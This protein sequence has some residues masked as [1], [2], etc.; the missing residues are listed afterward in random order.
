MSG[1]YDALRN[2]IWNEIKVYIRR[3]RQRMIKYANYRVVKRKTW[4]QEL[5]EDDKAAMG[6][7]PI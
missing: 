1:E 3:Y 7:I 4:P 6:D 2:N 5:A